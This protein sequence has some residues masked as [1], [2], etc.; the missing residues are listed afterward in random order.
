MDLRETCQLFLH[1]TRG[2]I[3]RDSE[4]NLWILLMHKDSQINSAEHTGTD[5]ECA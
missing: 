1:L 3:T 2:G 5:S 4:G